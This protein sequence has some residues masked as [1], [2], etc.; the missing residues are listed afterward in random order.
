MAHHGSM[1]QT[2]RHEAE[3][4]LKEGKVRL[5]VATSSLELG[6]DI[7]SVD[8]VCQIGSPR[9]IGL[10]LQRVGRSGHSLLATPK[11]RLFPLTRDE[12]LECMALIRGVRRGNLDRLTIPPWPLDVLAQQMV[13]ECAARE[14]EEDALFD[15][16]R[17][18]YP[19]RDLSRER[20]EQVVQVLSRGVAPREGRRSAY[21]HRDAVNGRLKGRRGARLA[22]LTSGGAIPDNADYD[23]IAEPEDVF[24]GKVNEDFA[25]ES[26]RG[27]VFLLGNTPWRVLRVGRGQMRVEDAQGAPPSVPFWLGEAPG[28]SSEL[29]DELSDIRE[30]LYHRM[31]QGDGVAW[32]MEELGVSREAAEQATEYV[33]EGVRVLGTVPTRKRIVAER[34]FDESGGMQVVVHSPYGSR[35]NRAWGMALRKQICRAFDFELQASA[36]EDGINLSLGP[37]LSFPLEDIFRYVPPRKADEVLTQAVLQAPLFP[38]RWRWVASRALAVLR[39]SSGRKVPPPLLRMRS[40][41]LLAAV[42]PEQV[43]CQDNAPPGDV[44]VPRP[45]PGLRDDAGLPDRGHGRGG[46]SA[47]P[48]GHGAGGP[49]GAGA[50]H[51]P[52]VGLQPPGPQRHAIRLPGQRPPGGAALQGRGAAPGPARGRPRPGLPGPGRHRAGG[53]RRLA[54][55][56]GRR[57]VPRRPPHPGDAAHRGRGQ[58]GRAAGAASAGRLAPE[59][60]GRASRGPGPL[61][62]RPRGLGSRRGRPSGGLSLSRRGLRPY[63]AGVTRP[64]ATPRT[65]GG[66]AGAGPG[67]GGVLRTL[68][69]HGAG[70]VPGDEARG[71]EDGPGPPGG[72]WEG[73]SRPFQDRRRSGGVLRPQGPGPD[74][75]GHHRPGSAGR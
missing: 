66:R 61:R 64:V 58:V 49:G 18:A 34:F 65:G 24:V 8:L 63:A 42:F 19:Y 27:D 57:R 38:L 52:A 43:Q 6:I 3:R 50:G 56:A 53:R 48:P 75:S 15:L 68:H 9:S 71:G 14:W 39:F 5:C 47:G 74:S 51:H 62:R 72:G 16:A 45:S 1:S 22:A 13:A 33:A 30:E 29:S 32:L 73:P 25:I 21:L 12:L 59:T 69:G 46:V 67:A 60:G 35:I 36:T 4:R 2:T 20:Y 37:S 54:R 44:E 70:G 28:R 11:G 55:G 7:G 23:V 10:L 31:H 40:D 41:D 17:A 26:L